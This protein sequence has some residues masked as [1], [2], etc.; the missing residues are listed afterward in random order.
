M[1]LL[2]ILII[3]FFVSISFQA[4]AW[5]QD[6][7]SK[8]K[9]VYE[10]FYSQIKTKYKSDDWLSYLYLLN[11]TLS[12][13]WDIWRI[14]KNN[15]KIF[16]DLQK[17]NS[18]KIFTIEFDNKQ[19]INKQKIS[20]N[21]L[22]NKYKIVSYNNDA[23]IIEDWI[24]YTYSFKNKYYFED[25]SKINKENLIYNWLYDENIFIYYD[26]ENNLNFIKEYKKVKI[27]SDDLIYW[28]PNKYNLLKILKNN[29]ILNSSRD[30]D[31][32]FKI[33]EVL[34]KQLTKDIYNNDEKIRIIYDYILKNISYSIDFTMEDYEIFSWIE[35]YINKSWVCEWYVE[36]FNLMLWF[37]NIDSQ[38]IIWD[39]IDAIDF[40]K[41]WHAWIKIGDYYYDITFD[42]P[43]WTTKT[44]TV[45][46]Y[47]YYKL[48]ED[49]FYTNRFNKC[50]TPENLKTSSLEYRKN[51]IKTNLS[52]LI[53]K[54][55]NDDYNL[56]KPFIFKE[57]YGL[58]PVKTVT[59]NDIIEAIWYKDMNNYEIIIDWTKK[60][61]K[62][63]NYLPIKDETIEIFLE[64][65]NFNLDWYMILNWHKDNWET[66]FIIANNIVYYD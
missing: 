52:K 43:V 24:W 50:K 3:L 16:F 30:D 21:N 13:I 59:A 47:H 55:K 17:L 32:Y 46:E 45:E 2:R 66:E 14:N 57:K 48:P 34:S 8:T 27:V 22:L 1:K 23:L 26:N 40:P 58:D 64:Q 31:N 11:E 54:Y 12:K 53:T 10:K 35:T 33:L 9:L 56:L 7:D 6:I 28:F 25:E 5:Y 18:E 39:V 41:I 44:K 42:D 60:S 38:I 15:E 4:N 49:I 62:S 29:K 37:N 19:K 51:L 65:I 63:L 20:N 36:L 61:V